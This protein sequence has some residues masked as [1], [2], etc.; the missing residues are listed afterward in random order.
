MNWR[1]VWLLSLGVWT[2]LALINTHAGYVQEKYS[3]V[4][5]SAMDRFGTTFLL[6]HFS[7]LAIC[8]P[9][10]LWSAIHYPLERG[11]LRTRLPLYIA[12]GVAVSAIHSLLVYCTHSF[13]APGLI[14]AKP[15][16]MV[17]TN[18]YLSMHNNL[19]GFWL[20]VI[21]AHVVVYHRQSEERSLR[22]SQLQAQVAESK[23]QALNMQLQPHF[24]FNTLH[25]IS[26]LMHKDV[27]A[28]DLMMTQLSDLLRMTLETADVGT[29]TLGQEIELLKA[30]VGIQQT[31]FSDMLSVTMDVAAETYDATVPFLLLQPIVENA[32][33]HGIS[34]LDSLGKISIHAHRANGW[35]QISVQD[36][37]PG[38]DVS[39][40][41]EVSTGI[42]LNNTK[43][44]LQA[45]YGDQYRFS[46]EQSSSGVRVSIAMPFL[47]S[48]RDVR[49]TSILA[50]GNGSLDSWSE[51]SSISRLIPPR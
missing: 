14:L 40:K 6:L 8:T 37:G 28:A 49:V 45:I 4:P 36:N 13:W 10:V 22:A 35:L 12:G 41:A 50:C 42:G 20:V 23:L 5:Q 17:L 51:S 19:Y 46:V 7:L 29:T 26:G 39:N 16:K 3:T 2:A 48:T 31:R 30:Y 47:S 32:V 44:R 24:L 1:K 21:V 18:F 9:L 38:F 11:Q 43:E 25:S 34:K 15:V 33:L 27:H